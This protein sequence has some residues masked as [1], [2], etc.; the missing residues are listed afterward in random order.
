MIPEVVTEYRS[1]PLLAK[2][3]LNK[4]EMES[5]SGAATVKPGS[6]PRPRVSEPIC[7]DSMDPGGFLKPQRPNSHGEGSP[8]G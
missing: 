2:L 1:V 8:Q 4:L 5:S 7:V 6:N 3:Q